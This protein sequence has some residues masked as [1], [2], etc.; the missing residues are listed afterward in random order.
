LAF[1]PYPHLIPP[2]CN[3]G[4][5]GP[6]RPLTAASPWTWVDHPASGLKRA[7]TIALFRLAFAPAPPHGLTSLHTLTRRLILQKARHHPPTH[8]RNCTPGSD[9][10]QAHGFRHYFT[11]LPGY[12]SPFPHGTLHYRSPDLFRL[13]RRSCQI[14]T[15]LH[16][17]RATRVRHP[18]TY[19]ILHL[20]DSHPLRSAFP[21]RSTRQRSVHLA[22]AETNGNVP[23]P[24]TRNACRLS[25]EPGLASSAFARR[26]SRNHSCFL[27]SRY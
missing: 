22:S 5:F 24:L 19:I 20:R 27:H 1:H 17:T 10:L 4:G 12:F 23:Q 26:Y 25:H 6:P 15:S 16:E 3:L 8:S 13:S 7:T 14:H 18:Y 9:G 11:P 21:H 2:V